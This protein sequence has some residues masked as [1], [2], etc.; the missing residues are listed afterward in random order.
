MMRV[1]RAAPLVLLSLILAS[2]AAYAQGTLADYGRAMT[3]RDKYQGL[4]VNVPEQVTW[5]E[6]SHRFWY[7]RAV[8]GGTEFILVNAE[9]QAKGPAFD[10]T[11][12]AATAPHLRDKCLGLVFLN[13]AASVGGSVAQINQARIVGGAQ[14]CA[15]TSQSSFA[16]F[17]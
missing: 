12:L 14:A 9:T 4:A 2:P 16:F 15:S 1:R 3:L 5:I 11:R 7:R 10:H 8:K 17:E 6:M 13:L